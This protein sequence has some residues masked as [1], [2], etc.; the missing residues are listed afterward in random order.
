MHVYCGRL[1]STQRPCRARRL[2]FPEAA[3]CPIRAHG[4]PNQR[5]ALEVCSGGWGCRRGPVHC[6]DRDRHGSFKIEAGRI[7]QIT[8][9]TFQVPEMRH[10][11]FMRKVSRNFHTAKTT[12]NSH[13]SLTPCM[14]K[15]LRK[16][17]VFVYLP[18]RSAP[19]RIRSRT[20][21]RESA[22]SAGDWGGINSH[23]SCAG[24][25]SRASLRPRLPGKVR[26]CGGAD[27]PVLR[28]LRVPVL[29]EEMLTIALVSS[30]PAVSAV[31]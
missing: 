12:V 29:R 13:V 6:L 22:S 28:R 2:Q 9:R 15:L 8:T 26:L 25:R 1:G 17:A 19:P 14:Y 5:W 11:V 4:V 16:P 10:C 21:L 24:L 3:N 30:L 23:H 27:D 20:L 31:G 18:T 7:K